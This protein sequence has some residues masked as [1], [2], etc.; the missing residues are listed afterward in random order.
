MLGIGQTKLA[1]A[2]GLAFQQVQKYEK[3]VNRI[4]AGR[5]QQISDFLQAPI[6]FFFAG[7]SNTSHTAKRTGKPAI[8]AHVNEF[9]ASAEELSLIKAYA[10][11]KR[12]N[13]RRAIVELVEKLAH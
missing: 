1:N 3:G 9:L 12:R 13:L 8:P 7:L 5:L 2:L 11:I 6:P 4:S 10:Q